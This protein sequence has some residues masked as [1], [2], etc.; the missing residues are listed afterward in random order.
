MS[1]IDDETLFDVRTLERNLAAGRV[2]QEQLDAH[3]EKLEECTEEDYEWTTTQVAKPSA[4]E[5]E[6]EA[7]A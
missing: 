6:E 3:I 1:Q 2:R 5:D 4:P 7:E